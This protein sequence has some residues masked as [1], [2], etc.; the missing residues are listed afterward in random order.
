TSDAR[1]RMLRN[2]I[3]QQISSRL[4]GAHEYA[5]MFKLHDLAEQNRYDLIVLDTPPTQ[6]ALDFLDAPERIVDA[7]DSPFIEWFLKPYMQ[8]GNV[9]SFKTLTIGAAF[10]LKRF[11]R[12]VGS[13]FL[14][15]VAHFF[16]EFNLIL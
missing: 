4:A 12:F 3:Y 1:D 9:S 13:D 5:A 16:V 2:R 7:I 15:D 6:N 10:V 14:E 11:A 8:E